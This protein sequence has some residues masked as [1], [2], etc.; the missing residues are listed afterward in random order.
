MPRE[1]VPGL[2]PRRVAKHAGLL[3]HLRRAAHRFPR[4]ALDLPLRLRQRT[5][6]ELAQYAA[7]IAG[8]VG[9]LAESFPIPGFG[10]APTRPA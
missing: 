10:L 7:R 5:Q 6:P 9:E 4:A 8:A 2:S 3:L 1:K